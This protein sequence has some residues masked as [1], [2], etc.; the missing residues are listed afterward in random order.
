MKNNFILMVILLLGLIS[1]INAGQYYI[2]EI[3]PGAGRVQ[4]LISQLNLDAVNEGHAG[5]V[6]IVADQADIDRLVQ[7]GIPFRV[8]RQLSTRNIPDYQSY[9]DVNTHPLC[10]LNECMFNMV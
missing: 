8:V 10:K 2:V 6:E 7:E 9:E 4:S 1:G 5:R 3:N